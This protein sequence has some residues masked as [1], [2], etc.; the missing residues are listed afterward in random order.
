LDICE[1]AWRELVEL[2]IE[3]IDE[4]SSCDEDRVPRAGGSV[5]A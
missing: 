2:D 4:E 3:E 5:V 1:E